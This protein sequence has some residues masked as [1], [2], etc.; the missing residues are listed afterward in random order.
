M[1]AI[2]QSEAYQRSSETLAENK[3]DTRF[4][5]RFYPR[6]IMAEVLLDA[7]SQVSGSPDGIRE[8]SEGL[9]CGAASGLRNVNSYFL[10]RSA[11][12]NRLTTCESLAQQ[13]FRQ[14]QLLAFGERTLNEPMI[15]VRASQIAC[16][17]AFHSC[18]GSC[19]N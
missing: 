10:N 15:L 6:R 8:L 3:V 16:V 5:S 18:S 9:A 4:Y 1:R 19:R 14:L 2:L 7:L 13:L 17:R 11:R 12:P